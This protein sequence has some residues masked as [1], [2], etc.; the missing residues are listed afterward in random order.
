MKVMIDIPSPNL[1]ET[2]HLVMSV[3]S[4]GVEQ[5]FFINNWMNLKI[6]WHNTYFDFVPVLVN[7]FT[8]KKQDNI[9]QGI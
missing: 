2:G 7:V 3:V 6:T 9:W 8:R 4:S 5:L 1:D